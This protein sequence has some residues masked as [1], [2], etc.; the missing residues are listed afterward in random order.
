MADTH[1]PSI[2]QLA[3]D[4]S[5]AKSADDFHA[6]LLRALGAYDRLNETQV[7]QTGVSLVCRAGCSLCCW[8]RVDV[9]APE[10]FLIADTLRMELTPSELDE[11]LGR[12]ASHAELVTRLTVFEHATRNIAC[13][14]SRDGW[15]SVYAVRPHT[16]RRHHSQD[17]AACQFTFDHPDDLEFP[18]AHSRELFH[19]MTEAMGLHAAVYEYFGFDNTIYELGSALEEALTDEGC[20]RRWQRKKQAFRRASVTPSA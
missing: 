1:L 8:L 15:C 6:A 5:G 19:E 11:L 2:T 20:W 17:L 7:A 18:G 9:Y 10:V 3:D 4:L 13:P 14:L 16:C 12:L